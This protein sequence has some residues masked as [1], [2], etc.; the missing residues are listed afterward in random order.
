MLRRVKA[1]Y[2]GTNNQS[3]GHLKRMDVSCLN[4]CSVKYQTRSEP[5]ER[6][7]TYK[8]SYELRTLIVLLWSVCGVMYI[9][10]F[11]AGGGIIAVG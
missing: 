11:H 5:L 6:C 2:F 7:E 9:G 8:L 3:N 10:E 1:L 4:M